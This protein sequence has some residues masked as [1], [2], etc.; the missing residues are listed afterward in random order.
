MKNEQKES[1]TEVLN[2]KT[3][4]LSDGRECRVVALKGRD[5]RMASRAS[6]DDPSMA[7]YAMAAQGTLIN[8]AGIVLEDLDEMPMKD[9]TKIL[10]VFGELN[11]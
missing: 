2:E 7:T 1:V 11:F 5:M 6:A 3:I 4:T 9:V 8:G 10:E